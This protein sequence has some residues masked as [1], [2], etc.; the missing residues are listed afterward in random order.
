[1]L[2]QKPGRSH[3]CNKQATRRDR[4]RTSKTLGTLTK[5]TPKRAPDI[6]LELEYGNK[7]WQ[8]RLAKAEGDESRAD[9]SYAMHLL[10]K[11]FSDEEVQYI[12]A[13]VS[14]N[15][16][17]R[18]KGHVDDYL[19]RTVEKAKYFLQLGQE[20]TKDIQKGI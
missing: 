12:L 13:E 15:L 2:G 8:D 19:Q 5:T 20:P 7:I 17:F 11:G 18:K 9:I 16:Q 6:A 14:E 4:A 3:H 1:M 10:R